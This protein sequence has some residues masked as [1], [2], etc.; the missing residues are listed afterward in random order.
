MYLNTLPG[1]WGWVWNRRRSQPEWNKRLSG[2]KTFSLPPRSSPSLRDTNS[3]H[4]HTQK[5]GKK[6]IRRNKKTSIMNIL[7]WDDVYVSLEDL[8]IDATHRKQPSACLLGTAAWFC[9]RWRRVWLEKKMWRQ[10]THIQFNTNCIN[11][12]EISHLF[13]AIFIFSFS[14]LFILEL[15][16]FH[17]CILIFHSK[18]MWFKY[19]IQLLF[20]CFFAHIYWGKYQPQKIMCIINNGHC[21]RVSIFTCV[22]VCVHNI[23][24]FMTRMHTHYVLV[25]LYFHSG[26]RVCV[27]VRIGQ[28]ALSSTVVI[29]QSI[30]KHLSLSKAAIHC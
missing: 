25:L 30:F 5:Y 4:T 20:F 11:F 14:L 9:C 28:S 17:I 24:C 29:S 15:F 10:N 27:C 23:R 2:A 6:K 26:L 1:R 16:F 3:T 13:F 12:A 18:N 21:L 22:C 19:N 8:R 7:L